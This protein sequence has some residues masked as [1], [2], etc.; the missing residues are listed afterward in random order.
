M[1]GKNIYDLDLHERVMV[2]SGIEAVRVPGGWIYIFD[3]AGYQQA[4][5]LFV[6]FHNEY[7]NVPL[8]AYKETANSY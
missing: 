7:Q 3:F 8:P 4:P 2:K 5:T 6:P 1:E